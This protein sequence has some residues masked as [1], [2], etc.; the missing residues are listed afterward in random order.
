MLD[1]RYWAGGVENAIGR[2]Q[3]GADSQQRISDDHEVRL[4]KVETR[5]QR[6]AIL[7]FL[8]GSGVA[9]NMSADQLADLIVRLL[10]GG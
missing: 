10:K 5:L 7:L 3:A 2:L 1:P 6:G 9:G 4:R 8:M